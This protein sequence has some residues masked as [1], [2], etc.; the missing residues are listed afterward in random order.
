MSLSIFKK[1]YIKEGI[2]SAAQVLQEEFRSWFLWQQRSWNRGFR[3]LL[4]IDLYSTSK[5][6]SKLQLVSVLL[7][8]PKEKE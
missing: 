2:V 1:K 4:S 8:I 7:M 5:E 3:L 6:F